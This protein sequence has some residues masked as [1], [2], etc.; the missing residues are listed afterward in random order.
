[1]LRHSPGPL[2]AALAALALAAV[3]LLLLFRY[4]VL[5][6][7]SGSDTVHGSG[8][9]AT[10]SRTVAPFSSV[11]LAGSN[12]VTIHV[13]GKQSVVVHA[14][15]NLLS[16]VTTK[17]KDRRLVIGNTSGSFT[18]KSP[19]RV[20]VRMPTL[21]ALTL[22]GSGVIRANGTTDRLEVTLA[23]SGDAQLSYLCAREVSAVVTGSG[24]ILVTATES[25]DAV[26]AGSGAIVYGGN[27]A[28]VTT[29]VTGSGAV[30]PG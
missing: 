21:D 22:A 23:G 28:R 4:D 16:H 14:D 19:M 12:I 18:T 5:S 27:P 25:I 24:R 20:D 11:V 30:M 26:I 13:G 7:S 29:S 6:T 17:V 10:E 2:V 3:G 9:A 15:D 1:M 8:T